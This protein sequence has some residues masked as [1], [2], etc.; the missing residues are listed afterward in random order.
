MRKVWG[1]T[2]WEEDLRLECVKCN[3]GHGPDS[4][5]VSQAASSQQPA[6]SSQQPA[7]SQPA[8]RQPA[9]SQPASSQQLANQTAA[10]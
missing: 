4:Q 10:N 7:D 6:D 5:P 3:Y 2:D 8:S 1:Q 9:A